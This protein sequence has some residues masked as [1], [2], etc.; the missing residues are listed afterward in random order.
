MYT[1]EYIQ[2]LN[3]EMNHEESNSAKKENILY[4]GIIM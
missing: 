4:V 3:H 1:S 2:W